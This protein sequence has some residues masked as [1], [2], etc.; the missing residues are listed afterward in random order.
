MIEKAAPLT[1][2]MWDSYGADDVADMFIAWKKAVFDG[3]IDTENPEKN[4]QEE[5]STP[6]ETPAYM[7]SDTDNAKEYKTATPEEEDDLP[8]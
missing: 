8:F 7:N 4:V 1:D 3:G 2:E 6:P 5:R